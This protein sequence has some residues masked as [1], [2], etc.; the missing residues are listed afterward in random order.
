LQ[1]ELD[2]AVKRIVSEHISGTGVIDIYA[3]AG[4]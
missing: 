1:A 3:E 4:M 2:M